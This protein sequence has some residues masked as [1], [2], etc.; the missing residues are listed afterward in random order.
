MRFYLYLAFVSL[1]FIIFVSGFYNKLILLAIF[2]LMTIKILQ[3]LKERERSIKHLALHDNLTGLPSRA[4]VEERASL[5]LEMAQRN[6]NKFAIIFLDFDKFKNIN[7]NFGHEVGDFLLKKMGQIL[8]GCL[9]REDVVSRIGG[10]E[11]IV[12]LPEIRSRIDTVRIA[13]KILKCFNDPIY[14]Q[15]KK[16]QIACSMGIS[17]YPDNARTLEEMFKKADVALYTI[18]ER[19]GN[20]FLIYYPALG[21]DFISV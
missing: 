17:L 8:T 20:S 21:T 12:L 1:V 5:A 4:L 18:K 14:I 10:D 15:G 3:F 7:D 9:R 11:F 2:V 13:Q 19:G 16:I 6:N